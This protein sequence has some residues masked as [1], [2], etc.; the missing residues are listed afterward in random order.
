MQNATTKKLKSKVPESIIFIVLWLGVFLIPVFTNR[1]LGVVLWDKIIISWIRICAF[2]IIFIINIY[3]LTPLFL[4]KKQYVRYILSTIV[5]IPV[6]LCISL[7]VESRYKKNDIT[8]M[9]PMEIG[10]GL[11]PMEFSKNMPP[12]VGYR[13]KQKN[14]LPSADLQFLQ[15]FAIA[16]LVKKKENY[17]R[18]ACNQETWM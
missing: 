10:P 14:I 1:L 11:P 15:S 3:F 17:S 13:L 6:I 7:Q 8:A 9:P 18:K 12:P 2:L 5:I 16:L 4:Y